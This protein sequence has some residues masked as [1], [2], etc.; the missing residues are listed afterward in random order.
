MHAYSIFEHVNLLY[1]IST[2][3]FPIFQR[4][5]V[6]FHYAVFMCTY[7]VPFPL[8]WWNQKGKGIDFYSA[9]LFVLKGIKIC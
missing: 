2:P 4:V 3:L 6:E 9:V 7:V 1:Y 5:L 8:P